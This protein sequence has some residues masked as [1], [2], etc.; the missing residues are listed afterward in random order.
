MNKIII[1]DYMSNKY[2]FFFQLIKIN[3][4]KKEKNKQI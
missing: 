2:I 4:E 3:E 1:G